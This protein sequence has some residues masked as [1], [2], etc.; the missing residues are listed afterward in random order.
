MTFVRLIFDF[1]SKRQWL[2]VGPQGRHCDWPVRRAPQAP[3]HQRE[4]SVD[5]AIPR[6]SDGFVDRRQ[7]TRIM[8]D[9]ALSDLEGVRDVAMRALNA[10]HLAAGASKARRVGLDACLDLASHS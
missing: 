6:R 7:T 10:H 3:C 9:P 4:L 8:V 1:G 5:Q 2:P